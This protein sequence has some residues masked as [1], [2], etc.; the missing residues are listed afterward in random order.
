MALLIPKGK[1]C[2]FFFFLDM[3]IKI[4]SIEKKIHK[5]N[6]HEKKDKANQKKN[7]QKRRR[8]SS[9]LFIQNYEIRRK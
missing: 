6:E 5:K 9:V 8:R 4:F 3:F 2:N 1:E 7:K